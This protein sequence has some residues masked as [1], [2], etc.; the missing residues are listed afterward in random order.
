[1]ICLPKIVHAS[2]NRAEVVIATT[3]N[4]DNP[5]MQRDMNTTEPFASQLRS[6]G[7]RLTPQRLVILNILKESHVHLTPAE[8]FEQA[9][10]QLPGLTEATVYRTL[11]FLAEHNLVLPAHVGNGQFVYEFAE[12]NHHHLICRLCGEMDEIGHDDL[13][14]LYALFQAKTGFKIDSVHLTFF[15]LCKACQKNE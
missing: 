9:R 1:V 13:E 11:I 4:N 10:R 15:G 5:Q 14:A 6:Q 12:H 3:L 2:Y 8:I 7:F